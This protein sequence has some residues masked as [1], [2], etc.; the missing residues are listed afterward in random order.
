MADARLRELERRAE[1]GDVDAHR[2]LLLERERAGQ[3]TREQLALAAHAGLEPARRALD[4]PP[5]SRDLLAWARGFYA[6][7]QEACVRVVAAAAAALLALDHR[8]EEGQATL[9]ALRPW[10]ECPCPAHAEAPVALARERWGSFVHAAGLL[11]ACEWVQG[12]RPGPAV[13]LRRDLTWEAAEAARAELER[14]RAGAA[15]LVAQG[16]AWGLRLRECFPL[17]DAVS[18]TAVVVALRRVSVPAPASFAAIH[19]VN[20]VPAVLHH[21][22]GKR[23]RAAVRAAVCEALIAPVLRP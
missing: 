6:F 10:L 7:G 23:D 15:D 20:A 19:G 1:T 5:P 9:D 8:V 3:V 22:K 11:L 18:S 4:A 16:A 2:R 21:A 17:A 12:E 14:T 13:V